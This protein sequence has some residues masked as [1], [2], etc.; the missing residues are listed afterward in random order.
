MKVLILISLLLTFSCKK[1]FRVDLYIESLCPDC[2]DFLTVSFAD[3]IKKP[4]HNEL[5]DVHIYPFGNAKETGEPGNYK[6]QCQHGPKECYG[7][8]YYACALDLFQKKFGNNQKSFEFIVCMEANVIDHEQNFDSTAYHCL[9]E[10]QQLHSL[11]K[12]CL[13]D[14]KTSNA[15]MHEIAVKTN[16]LVPKKTHVP[17][18]I[19]DNKWDSEVEYLIVND[20][21]SYLKDHQSKYLK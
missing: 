6:F 4:D 15:L 9:H 19:I 16:S 14:K 20:M 13:S 8:M 11:L 18:V 10:E 12:Q 1:R 17:W 7:N 21:Y 5:A 3:F 2:M